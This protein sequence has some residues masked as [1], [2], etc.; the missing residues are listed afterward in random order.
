MYYYFVCFLYG[1]FFII[2]GPVLGDS[3]KMDPVFG[4]YFM[5]FMNLGDSVI[6]LLFDLLFFF[7]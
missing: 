3:F 7:S 1:S 4:D 6:N 5:R 2:F